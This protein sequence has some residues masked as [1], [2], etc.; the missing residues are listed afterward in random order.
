[1][2]E[3]FQR[4]F[5]EQALQ[6]VSRLTDAQKVRLASEL[7]GNTKVKEELVSIIH[8]PAPFKLGDME[9]EFK[10]MAPAIESTGIEGLVSLTSVTT[11]PVFKE[12]KYNTTMLNTAAKQMN[13]LAIARMM[14]A[15]PDKYIETH[16][17]ERVDSYERLWMSRMYVKKLL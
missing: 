5:Y 15:V 2:N 6:A 4:Q 10:T 8:K 7:A 11:L 13:I 12:T 1:M 17:E 3:S 9:T 14:E 16:M